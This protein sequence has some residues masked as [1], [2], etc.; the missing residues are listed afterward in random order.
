MQS[1]SAICTPSLG[2]HWVLQLVLK[3]QI[4]VA[5]I[6]AQSAQLVFR[7]LKNQICKQKIHQNRKNKTKK[8]RSETTMIRLVIS[9]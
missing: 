4:G 2:Q 9:L 1:K 7:C 8:R 3:L 6:A 5:L